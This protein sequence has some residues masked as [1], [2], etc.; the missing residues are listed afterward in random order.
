MKRRLLLT[1][2]A[3]AI[4]GLSMTASCSQYADFS[5]QTYYFGEYLTPEMVESIYN[6]LSSEVTEKYPIET[7]PS[8]EIVVY[9]TTSGEVYHMSSSCSSIKRSDPKNVYSGSIKQAFRAGKERPCGVCSP[10]EETDP[11]Q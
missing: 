8:G 4:L 11:L 6:E 2:L 9:W 10:K 3:I 5:E 7:T 1:A